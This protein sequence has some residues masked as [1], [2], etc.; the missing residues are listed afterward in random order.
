MIARLHGFLAPVAIL[1]SAAAL[2]RAQPAAAPKGSAPPP[3]RIVLVGDSTVCAYPAT[4]P[5]RGWGQYLEEHFRDGTAAVINLAASGRSTKTFFREGR[6]KK[7]LEERPDYVLIQFGHNDSHPPGRPES[8]DA[9][10][11]YKDYLRRYLDEARAAGATPVLVTPVVRRTFGEDGK[12]RDDLR[13]YADAMKE[14]GAEK[15][16]P[17]IDLHA[18]SRALV[19]RLGPEKSAELANKKGDATHFN[20]QGARAMADL[21]V[22]DLPAAAPKLRAYLKAPVPD[23]RQGDAAAPPA[24]T[25]L[26]AVD[27]WPDGTMPRRGARE[28]D[29]ESKKGTASTG[30][31]TSVGRR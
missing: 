27:V 15:K 22:N 9:A 31:P 30:L 17:V 20:E 4:R 5:E 10:T 18:S 24:A 3:V 8:T 28:A 12:L 23:G 16:V 14:V 13:R 11:D 6:W 21:V 1:L 19:E 25:P 29:E 26:A 7:A 2:A